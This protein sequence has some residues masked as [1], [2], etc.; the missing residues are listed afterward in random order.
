[1]I[2]DDTDCQGWEWIDADDVVHAFDLTNDIIAGQSQDTGM[3]PTRRV[4]VQVPGRSGSFV[5]DRDYAERLL[6]LEATIVSS[7]AAQGVEEAIADWAQ[8]FN[9]LRGGGRL[10]R[11]R[12]DGITK[13]VLFCD[14]D[15]GFGIDQSASIWAEGVQQAVLMFYA[16]DPFWYDDDE[17]VVVFAA[18]GVLT[19]FFPIPNPTTGS[20]VTLTASEVFAQQVITNDGSAEV[21]PVWTIGGPASAIVLENLT[22]GERMAFTAAGGVTLLAG[23]SITIDTR[24]GYTRVEHSDGT[25]LAPYL[26]DDSTLWPLAAG[27]NDV[28][29]EMSGTAIG[30]SSARLG[31]YRRWVTA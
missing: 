18:G 8:R 28:S 4:A 12:A 16:G 10:R 9:V 14:Y 17:T 6:A 15:D 13:R 19:A 3:P 29:V 20:F 31:Y 26:S 21:Y 2:R 1:M 7:A 30:V 11:T 27:D 22:T 24:P 23:E 25:N 5:L